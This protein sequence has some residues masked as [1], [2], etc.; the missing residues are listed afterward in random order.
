MLYGALLNNVLYFYYKL[1]KKEYVLFQF[2][3]YLQ[4]THYFALVTQSGTS[5]FPV[6]AELPNAVRAQLELVT[7][8]KGETAKAYDL[9]WQ[10]LHKGY[11]GTA[12]TY[13][14]VTEVSV[15][16]NYVFARRYFSVFWVFYV[17]LFRLL[18]FNNPVKELHGFFSTRG[19]KRSQYLKTPL[20]A[21]GWETFISPLVAENPKVTVVIPT[22][23]RYVYLKDVLKDL[24]AQDY[25]NFEVIV[26]DQSFPFQED[27]YTSF[28]LDLKLIHQ[29]EKAL[30]L[31]R[32]TAIKQAEGDYILLFDDDSRVHSN[33]IRNH[34]K[35]L[36]FFKADLSSGVS[37]SKVGAKIPA[38]YA[39]FRL[40][41]QLDT[42]NVLLKKRVFLK[43]GLFDRQ[44]E[45]QRMGD[46]EYGLRA[47]LAGYLNVSNPYAERLH[48]KVG[49]GGLRDMGSW[50]AFRTQNILAPRPIP[51]VLYLFRRYYGNAAAKKTLWRT[52]PLSIMPYKFKTHKGMMVLGVFVSLWLVPF[53]V[54]QVIRSWKAS[55]KKIKSGPL[56]DTL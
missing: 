52:I 48:L 13:K 53:V 47:Y 37:I 42:G 56:I 3:K 1:S 5:A 11:L 15:H 39:F 54:V 49:S 10:A 19:V 8:Y 2:L 6:V 38:H 16:D 12:D 51:S 31:A 21:P 4:P 40:S 7:D 32:N 50:D 25:S 35:C 27:F 55:S 34:L 44:F 30:W 18:S 41:D 9:S 24:E 17:L 20:T 46:G 28:Q 43:L 14:T 45:K 22:L 29:E 23:N 36:D 33:W 26:V